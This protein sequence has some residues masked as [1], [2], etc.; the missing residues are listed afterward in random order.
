MYPSHT[1]GY[2]FQIVLNVWYTCMKELFTIRGDT[3]LVYIEVSPF[4]VHT[5]WWH[6]VHVYMLLW[7]NNC[8]PGTRDIAN[9]INNH[10]KTTWPL[11]SHGNQ[12]VENNNFLK[13]KHIKWFRIKTT[14]EVGL[15]NMFFSHT[16]TCNFIQQWM[17]TVIA[18]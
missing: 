18:G 8:S 7:Y 17:N 6:A 9:I 2:S 14:S 15:W 1:T 10:H 12:N 3:Q 5:L 11:F 13:N 16:C 4:I